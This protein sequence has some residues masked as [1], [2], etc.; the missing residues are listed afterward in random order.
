MKVDIIQ[1][2]DWAGLYIDGKLV[3]EDHS[4]EL[5]TL[6]SHTHMDWN[7]EWC[8]GLCENFG[9]RMPG[10]MDEVQQWKVTNGDS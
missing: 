5:D 4:I 7:M 9:Y 1:D 6:I 3:H 2:D 10:T 8:E